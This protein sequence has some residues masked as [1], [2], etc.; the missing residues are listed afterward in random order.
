MHYNITRGYCRPISSFLLQKAGPVILS[1][2]LGSKTQFYYY[3]YQHPGLKTIFLKIRNNSD[4][5]FY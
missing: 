4:Q 1:E 3:F 5:K 2:A